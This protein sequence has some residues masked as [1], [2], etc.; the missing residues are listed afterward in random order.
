M[1]NRRLVGAIKPLG[2]RSTVVAGYDPKVAGGVTVQLEKLDEFLAFL[3]DAPQS[4]PVLSVQEHL[5][6][7]RTYLL[8]AM[9]EELRLSLRMAEEAIHGIED[10][11]LR[12]RSLNL[13]DRVRDA[14]STPMM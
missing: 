11:R 2:G 10:W 13:L 12:K 3:A 9:P 7:A 6:S 8:G 14:R 5:H 1:G 4:E